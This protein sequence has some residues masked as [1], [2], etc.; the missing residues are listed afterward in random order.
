MYSFLLSFIQIQTMK[1][2][3][4]FLSKN[5]DTYWMRILI[6]LAIIMAIV[7]LFKTQSSAFHEGFV[8]D[9]AY[10]FKTG[11][12]VYDEFYVDIYDRLMSCKERANYEIGQVIQATQPDP[13]FDIFLDIGSGTGHLVSKLHEKGFQS[14][15][16]ESSKTMVEYCEKHH[17]EIGI[18]LGDALVPDTYEKG[19]FSHIL[20]VGFTIYHIEN[21]A[22][23]LQNV[24]SWLRPGGY[25]IV[26]LVDQ[27]T[28]DTIIP[29]GRPKMVQ[30]PQEHV[31]E[32]ITKTQ[33]D[34]IDFTYAGEYIFDKNLTVFKETFVDGLSKNVR[35]NEMPL[36]MM[37]K[38]NV[39]QLI[40]KVGFISVGV[41]D[42]F[43]CNG[44]KH[45]YLY[46][47]TK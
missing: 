4:W 44:D 35:Q 28:F 45:Q 43:G 3:S 8:Q 41:Y 17:P 14:Y 42:M 34:F 9:K 32:R 31:K 37:K 20:C 11:P 27:E 36:Y 6:L 47:F 1:I 19:V 39:V 18:K 40:M 22:R 25:F 21:K 24:H 10:V 15:G 26:H 33:V 23:L 29:V 13:K 7:F 46:I 2:G 16:L 38:Q 30:S 5:P 12:D